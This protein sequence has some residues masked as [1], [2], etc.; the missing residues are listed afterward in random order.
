[1]QQPRGHCN[2]APACWRRK[3]GPNFCPTRGGS[4]VVPRKSQDRSSIKET[5]SPQAASPSAPSHSHGAPNITW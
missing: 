5:S 2:L 1:M 4:C 3:L